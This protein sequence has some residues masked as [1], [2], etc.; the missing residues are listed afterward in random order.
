MSYIL[1]KIY[2]K[3]IKKIKIKYIIT[4]IYLLK[5][6]QLIPKLINNFNTRLHNLSS[7]L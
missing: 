7:N 5:K 3:T 6:I 2:T 1:L 4:K